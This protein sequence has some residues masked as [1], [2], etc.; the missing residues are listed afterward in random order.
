MSAPLAYHLTWTAYGTWLPGDERGWIDG[1]RPGVQPP[2]L[3]QR[4]QSQ[5]RLAEVPVRFDEAQ[6]SLIE[7]TIREHTRLRGWELHAVHVGSYHVHVV[8]TGAAAPETILNQFK[9]WCSRRLSDAAG[10]MTTVAQR[11]GRRRWFT[12]HGSTKWINDE[13]YLEQAIHYVR[14]GQ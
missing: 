13:Q 7:D 8:V 5:R 14:E 1:N 11:A 10:L 9:A 3:A 6:R 12:E 4:H 2:D